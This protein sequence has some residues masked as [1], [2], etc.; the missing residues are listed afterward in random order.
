MNESD[1]SGA[2]EPEVGDFGP[3][4]ETMNT[5][6]IVRQTHEA[7]HGEYSS[8]EWFSK[9]TMLCREPAQTGSPIGRASTLP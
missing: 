2:L 3:L 5:F 4:M 9:L 7:E 6:P 1:A 8:D